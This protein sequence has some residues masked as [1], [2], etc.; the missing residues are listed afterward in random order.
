MHLLRGD[1]TRSHLSGRNVEETRGKI[2]SSNAI[3]VPEDTG[4]DVDV[5]GEGSFA[6]EVNRLHDSATEFDDFKFFTIGVSVGEKFPS[7][8]DEREGWADGDEM[9]EKVHCFEN[10]ARGPCLLRKVLF[11]DS[12]SE[13]GRETEG[14]S[15]FGFPSGDFD[16]EVIDLD[17]APCE[18][19]TYK[20][21]SEMKGK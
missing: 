5:Q 2:E 3:R 19:A 16:N 6:A 17:F 12:E 11:D 4:R 14:E 8:G 15:N 13:G 10:H 1:A 18:R 7:N 21:T 9:I 20:N